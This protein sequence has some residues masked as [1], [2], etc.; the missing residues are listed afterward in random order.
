MTI[1]VITHEQE[2]GDR[3]EKIIWFQ[4]GQ[5]LKSRPGI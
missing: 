4:D 3:A 2:V 5:N 1:V